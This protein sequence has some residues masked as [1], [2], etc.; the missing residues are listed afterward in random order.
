MHITAFPPTL[1]NHSFTTIIHDH[2]Q[3]I[4]SKNTNHHRTIFYSTFILIE[5]STYPSQKEKR[6]RGQ[7]PEAFLH[8]CSI[9]IKKS[10][11]MENLFDGYSHGGIIGI[12]LHDVR[13]V[14][15][16]LLRNLIG[17]HIL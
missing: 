17:S 10:V 14:I 11:Q 1:E 7:S 3:C 6:F 13:H 4:F 15:P 5:Y 8:P 16:P 2:K 9:K 12:H